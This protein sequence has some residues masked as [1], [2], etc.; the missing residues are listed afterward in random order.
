MQFW[1]GISPISLTLRT[2]KL[3]IPT[4][5]NVM[6]IN[7]ASSR[8]MAVGDTDWLVAIIL[9]ISMLGS[10]SLLFDAIKTCRKVWV[11][12]HALYLF[13]CGFNVYYFFK[14]LICCVPMAGIGREDYPNLR[15]VCGL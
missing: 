3:L 8:A 1:E 7:F 10:T 14:M 5:L 12:Q 11:W 2:I 6:L 9:M 4:A 13:A 15:Q